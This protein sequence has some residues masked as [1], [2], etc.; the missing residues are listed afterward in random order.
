MIR[1]GDIGNVMTVQVSFGLSA[2]ESV[3]RVMK[4]ELG[5]SVLMDIGMYAVNFAD[6]AFMGEKPT[7]IAATGVFTEAGVDLSGSIT[8]I[9][10]GKRIAQMLY[11]GS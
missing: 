6:I 3:D 7:K 5:G 4:P 2:L 8:F 11:T 1:D 10:E 9:Y